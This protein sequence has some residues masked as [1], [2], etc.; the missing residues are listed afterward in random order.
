M[1]PIVSIE[2]YRCTGCG[3]CLPDCPVGALEVRDGKSRLISEHLC[4]GAGTCVSACPNEAIRIVAREA[5]PYDEERV[6]RW[7]TC[8]GAPIVRAHLEALLCHGETALY[9]QALDL[10]VAAC[11]AVP[12]HGPQDPDRGGDG[13]TG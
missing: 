8:Q 5:E 10:L 9:R 1:R 11:V 12:P 2:E 3:L 6:V 4:D 7:I 13:T